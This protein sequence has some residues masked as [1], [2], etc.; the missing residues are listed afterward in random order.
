[1]PLGSTITSGP[2]IIVEKSKVVPVIKVFDPLV[3]VHETLL[4]NTLIRRNNIERKVV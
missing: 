4:K 2:S 3:Y 1:M